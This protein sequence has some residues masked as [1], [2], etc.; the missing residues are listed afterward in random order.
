[1]REDAKKRRSEAEISL[2]D[3]YSE[4][5]AIGYVSLKC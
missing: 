4:G 5:V 3:Q 2:N 1:M